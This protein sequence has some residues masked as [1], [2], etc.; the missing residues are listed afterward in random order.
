MNALWPI[1]IGAINQNIY[2]KDVNPETFWNVLGFRSIIVEK[3][4]T[5]IQDLAFYLYRL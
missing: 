1:G 4:C 3:P 5:L 2:R